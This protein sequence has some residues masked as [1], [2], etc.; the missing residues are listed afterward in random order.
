MQGSNTPLFGAHLFALVALSLA[1]C[2]NDSGD[3]AKLCIE[4]APALAM[5]C[6]PGSD[7]K[8]L[9]AAAD[10]CGLNGV[11]SPSDDSVEAG[12]KCFSEGSCSFACTINAAL[13]PCGVSELTREQFVCTVCAGQACEAGMTQCRNGQI[14][15]CL[16]D[17]TWSEA[18]DCAAGLVCQRTGAGF[19]CASGTPFGG[20]EA[21]PTSGGSEAAPTSGGDVATDEDANECMELIMCTQRC[22]DSDSICRDECRDRASPGANQRFDAFGTCVDVNGCLNEDGTADTACLSENCS[23]ELRACGVPV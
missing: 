16:S 17:G 13:C 12:G 9:A 4:T 2:G 5:Q 11:Y 19:E 14:S 6:A 15:E 21:G 20:S 22:P 3:T 8:L 23:E 1:G 18:T 10:G 7:W